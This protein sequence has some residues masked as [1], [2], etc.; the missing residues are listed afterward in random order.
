MAPPKPIPSPSILD[1]CE[2]LGAIYGERRWRSKDGQ[3]LY[4]WDSLHGEIEVFNKRGKHLG[5]IDPICGSLIKDAI[6]GR[7]IDV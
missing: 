6:P 7:K 2:Y 1:N 4:T 3:R 5:A